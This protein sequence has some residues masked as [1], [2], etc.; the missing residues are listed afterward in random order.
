MMAPDL[1]QVSSARSRL[2]LE[3]EILSRLDTDGVVRLIDRGE[4]TD[5][6]PFLVMNRVRGRSFDKIL[7]RKKA[8]TVRE[9][10]KI[11]SPLLRTLYTVHK[12]GVSHCDIKPANIMIHRTVY[13]LTVTLIDFGVADASWGTSSI[14]PHMAGTVHYMSPEQ[15]WNTGDPSPMADLWAVAVVAYEC[16]TGRLP[17]RGSSVSEVFTSLELG[18]FYPVTHYRPDLGAEV[19]AFFARALSPQPADRFDSCGA[20]L[21]ALESLPWKDERVPRSCVA[22]QAEGNAALPVCRGAHRDRWGLDDR[23]APLVERPARRGTERM[24]RIMLSDTLRAVPRKDRQWIEPIRRTRRALDRYFFGLREPC[25][26][27]QPT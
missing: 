3:A 17:F 21:E 6:L 1:A 18:V 22:P 19:D 27:M 13:D 2:E 12:A 16:L 14:E 26:R 9:T 11:L 15:A 20:M 8:L 5:G 10:V 24:M 23:E 7:R 4:T 25:F